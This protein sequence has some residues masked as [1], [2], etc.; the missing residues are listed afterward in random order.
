MAFELNAGYWTVGAVDAGAFP[1]DGRI[2]KNIGEYGNFVDE[3]GRRFLGPNQV[4]TSIAPWDS[5]IW[6]AIE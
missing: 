4:Q 3:W 2:S 6:E 5:T 1:Q